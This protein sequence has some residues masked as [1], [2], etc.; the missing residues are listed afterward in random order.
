MKEL[1]VSTPNPA[2]LDETL[3]Q[4]GGLVGQ[5]PDGS[6]RQDADGNYAVR[7]VGADVGFLAFS[8][9]HQGYGKVV[10]EREI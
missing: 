5:N 4:I 7:S 1:I 9:A 2:V 6:Y 8:M 3:Q 10:G